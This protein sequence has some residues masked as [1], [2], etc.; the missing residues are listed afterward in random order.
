MAL[1]SRNFTLLITERKW[2]FISVFVGIFLVTFTLLVLVNLVPNEI[3]ES[4]PFVLPE[5]KGENP[6]RI[7]ISKIAT[8][9]RI[10]NPQSRD[11]AV[12]DAALLQGAVH[13]PGS[14]LLGKGNM[15]LFGHSSSYSIVNNPAYKAFNNLK[16]LE[17]GDEIVVYSVTKK[18]FYSVREVTL[19][20]AGK[21]LVDF[22]E[23]RKMLTLS[24]CN[25]FGAKEERYV[26]V[27]D[28]V[29]SE[30]LF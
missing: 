4:L 13:Y 28:F 30:P 1:P 9:V 20:N 27:A 21:A 2:K 7:V 3:S 12:L 22:T 8:D 23:T 17:E 14:G 26:V 15:F 5:E 19:E 16:K 11:I 6:S 25:T 18:Y 29:R 10:L 24:T